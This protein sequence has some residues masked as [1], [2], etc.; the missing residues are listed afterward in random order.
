MVAREELE[1]LSIGW[2]FRKIGKERLRCE[3]NFKFRDRLTELSKESLVSN[4]L[5]ILL[6]RPDDPFYDPFAVSK[7]LIIS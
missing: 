4:Q 7:V 6:N 5:V 3:L 2:E 1:R